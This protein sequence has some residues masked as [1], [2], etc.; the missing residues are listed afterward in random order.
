MTHPVVGKTYVT[1]GGDHITITEE[2][3]KYADF[4]TRFGIYY[5][6]DKGYNYTADGRCL[7]VVY[8][9]STDIPSVNV[10]VE[11]GLV[12]LHEPTYSATIH[13]THGTVEITGTMIHV[14][15]HINWNSE[16]EKPLR[17]DMSGDL[18]TVLEAAKTKREAMKVD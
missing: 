10:I 12:S 15:A 8:D 13:F 3:K 2:L 16:H 1:E 17:V 9:D 11:H 14:L 4:D 7:E 5:R 6:S 18:I